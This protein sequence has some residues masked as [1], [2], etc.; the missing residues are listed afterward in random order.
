MIVRDKPNAFKLLFIL[1]GSVVPLIFGQIAFF[2]LLGAAVAAAQYYYPVIFPTFT[3]S[4]LALLGVA[5]SLFLGF[6]NNASYE[7]WWEARK[8]WGQ[9]VIDARSLSRQVTSYVDESAK[10]GAELQQRMIYLTIAFSHALRHHLRQSDP[11]SDIEKYLNPEDIAA[12]RKSQNLPDALLRLMGKKLGTCRHKNLLSD[13]LIQTIDDNITSMA[14]VQAGCERIQSTPL[15]FA[16]MLLV[17]RTAYLYCLILPFGI[18]GSIGL[19]TPLFCAI[20][21]YTFFG[22]DALSEELEEPFG[23]SANDLPLSSISRGIE[24]NLL[25]ILG[26]T[27]LPAPIQPIKHRLI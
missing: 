15:P 13:F 21:T 2:T 10:G 5:L 6:R 25:E 12:L 3:L 4:P 16:Y 27:E 19:I 11:W 23:L 7:R 8:Q 20:I 14:T 1:R 9:L 22:L 17:Q 24:I 18:V 26:V